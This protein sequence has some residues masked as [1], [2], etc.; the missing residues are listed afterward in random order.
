MIFERTFHLSENAPVVQENGFKYVSLAKCV[1]LGLVIH[2][3]GQIKSWFLF[4][5]PCIDDVGLYI[6]FDEQQILIFF[7]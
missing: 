5:T 4:G 1:Y 3:F 6:I 7:F 2:R